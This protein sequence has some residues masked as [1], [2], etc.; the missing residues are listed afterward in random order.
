MAKEQGMSFYQKD[1][2]NHVIGEHACA[3]QPEQ[4]RKMPINTNTIYQVNAQV[5]G[6]HIKTIFPVMVARYTPESVGSFQPYI[7]QVLRVVP[8]DEPDFYM[9]AIK[10]DIRNFRRMTGTLLKDLKNTDTLIGFN[11]QAKKNGKHHP[12]IHAK[13]FI[14][15][16]L[17]V[18]KDKKDSPYIIA[19][20]EPG[21]D[22]YDQFAEAYKP[23]SRE[24]G[25]VSRAKLSA[26]QNTWGHKQIS[27]LGYKLF[28]QNNV[29]FV[30]PTQ[31][32]RPNILALYRMS[33][34]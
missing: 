27:Q 7:K 5:P 6:K 24:V 25:E 16:A 30:S 22:T 31:G 33:G 3:L 32:M 2:Y 26:M 19:D 12:A 23:T 10:F 8:G 15:W 1:I 13:Y 29:Q 20:Y 18:L 4:V 11:V 14:P 21:S 34:K 28:P 9:E 17:E